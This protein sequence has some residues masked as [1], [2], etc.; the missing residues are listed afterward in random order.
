MR[1]EFRIRSEVYGL[2][3]T[4]RTE[5]AVAF[6]VSGLADSAAFTIYFSRPGQKLQNG[7][8][9]PGITIRVSPE[10]R[11][12]TLLFDAWRVA[13]AYIRQM[14]SSFRFTVACAD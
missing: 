9:M 10:K 3:E 1:T 7:V 8:L 5:F 6:L 11:H 12:C 2:H 13:Y 14:A 4:S